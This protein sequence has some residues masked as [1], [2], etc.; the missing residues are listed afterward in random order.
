MKRNKARYLDYFIDGHVL[1]PALFLSFEEHEN[2]L[3][4]AF[5]GKLEL[6]SKLRRRGA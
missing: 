2:L 3:D 6:R 4:A 5:D 1:I